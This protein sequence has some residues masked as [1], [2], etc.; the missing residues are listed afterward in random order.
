MNRE[1][2]HAGRAT[3]YRADRRAIFRSRPRGGYVQRI[4]CALASLFM[5]GVASSESART[6]DP[7]NLKLTH[8]PLDGTQGRDWIVNNYVDLD[9]APSN[10]QDWMGRADGRALTYDGHLGMD[11]DIPSFRE[12]DDGSAIVRAAAPGKV[13]LIQQDREDRHTG[14]V[15]QDWNV[16]TIRHDSGFNLTYGH[17]KKKSALVKVGDV[18]S[19]GQALAV[20]G[21]S[22]CST[23]PHIHFEVEDCACRPVETM[24]S[25]MWSSPPAYDGP[26]G[27]MDVVLTKGAPTTPQ[28]KDPLPDVSVYKPTDELGVG[29]TMGGKDGDAA[30]LQVLDPS[31]TQLRVGNWTVNGVS[32]FSHLHPS[33]HFT[34]EDRPGTWTLN[35]TVNGKLQATRHFK[36]GKD[37]AGTTELTRH[38]V[39]AA[40]YQALFDEVTKV[41][42]R[43]VWLDGYDVA[44]DVYY[45]VIFQPVGTTRW[46]ARHALNTQDFQA[47]IEHMAPGY[48]PM[49]VE[50]YLD[51]GQARYAILASQAPMSPWLMY[52]GRTEADHQALLA[53]YRGQGFRPVNI[54]VVSVQGQRYFTALYDQADVGKWEALYDIPSA[55]FQAAFIQ[56]KNQGLHLAYLNA[57][58]HNGE[59]FFT[60]IWNALPHADPVLRH[61]LDAGQYRKEWY[62][63][64]A[65]GH[66]TRM[67]TGYASDGPAFAGLW[68]R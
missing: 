30:E 2:R 49:Q 52:H 66:A 32:R 41:G 14:C 34:L 53:Q 57:Y 58:R 21:S 6:C 28:I 27:V 16:I 43:P 68:A 23:Q 18:V 36:V 40:S 59:V 64:S 56:K 62:G 25:G 20:A 17:I 8:W 37:G 55:D 22:G 3:A 61:G 19:P 26:S 33:F 47:V 50:S 7:A 67:I 65:T 9:P 44:G 12:M 13:V 4:A 60:T 15:N 35:V 11:I 45:N 38:G 1:Q 31:N 29:L 54:A 10:T 46:Q 42:Y 24:Q 63:L 39:A 51:H 48:K 5:V